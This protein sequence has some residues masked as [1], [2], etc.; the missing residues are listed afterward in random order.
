MPDAYTYIAKPIDATYTRV[1]SPG[2]QTYDD[3]LISYDDSSVFYDSVD[4]N[5][6]TNIP[7]PTSSSNSF[8]FTRG[9]TLGLM[10]PLTNAIP[11]TVSGGD[12]YT[13]INKPTT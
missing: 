6:Y 11:K 9:M 2:R 4:Y 5:A 7:K 12:D 10:I 13:Y 8:T 1:N 3:A